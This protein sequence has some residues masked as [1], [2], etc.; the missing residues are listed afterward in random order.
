[1]TLLYEQS[2]GALGSTTLDLLPPGDGSVDN[3]AWA[4]YGG[5]VGAADDLQIYTGLLR[6]VPGGG[7]YQA[8]VAAKE[9]AGPS[10]FSP[11]GVFS[12]FYVRATV[13][14]SPGTAVRIGWMSN[15][16]NPANGEIYGDGT[17]FG[18]LSIVSTLYVGGA[19]TR[20]LLR[21]GMASVA[22]ADTGTVEYLLSVTFTGGVYSYYLDNELVGTYSGAPA[23]D[24]SLYASA[25]IQV[26]TDNPNAGIM[27]FGVGSGLPDDPDTPR[28]WRSLKNAYETP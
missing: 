20:A 11:L 14:V 28:F 5:W 3:A 26:D 21:N 8:Y 25:Q 23:S 9:A 17:V 1:M 10:E 18:A 27:S 4:K 13:R 7:N 12:Q 6:G 15:G 16:V 24:I 19:E 22:M 2:F